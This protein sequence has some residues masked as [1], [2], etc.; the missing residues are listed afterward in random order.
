MEMKWEPGCHNPVPGWKEGA[1]S[2]AELWAP[3]PGRAWGF[4]RN[5]EARPGPGRARGAEGRPGERVFAWGRAEKPVWILRG[6]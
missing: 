6:L 1:G 3:G 2:A 4:S 5:G